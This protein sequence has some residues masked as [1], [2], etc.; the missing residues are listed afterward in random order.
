MTA[1]VWFKNDLR[2][3][4]NAALSQACKTGEPVRAIYLLSPD[5]F[6]QHHMAE[7]KADYIRRALDELAKNLG[8]L[9]IPLDFVNASHFSDAP[10]AISQ[11]CQAHKVTS[12][13]CNAEYLINEEQRDNA[14]ENALE[15]PLKTYHEQL[16]AK[17]GSILNQQDKPYRVFTPFSKTFK[18]RLQLDLPRCHPRPKPVSAEIKPTKCPPLFGNG[19]ASNWPT[20]E[21]ALLENLRTFCRERAPDYKTA[22]DFPAVDGTSRLSAPLS[23]GL[24][25]ARQCLARLLMEQEPKQ[26]EHLWSN[27][28]GVGCWL[29]ELIWREFYHH[30]Y[31]QFS[32][33]VKGKSFKP[34]Y[35]AI[36]WR[37]NQ[38]E[39]DAWCQGKTGYPIVDAAMRQLNQT[40]W[41][42]N[43]LRMITAS[44]LV[45]DL[46][47]D[48]R[49]GEQY[50]MRHLIDGDFASNNGGWQ[51]AASSGCDAAP[52]FRIFNPTTQGQRFDKD[53]GFIKHFLPELSGLQGKALHQPNTSSVNY[54]APIVDHKQARELT[55]DMYKLALA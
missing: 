50:F 28:S 6:Q 31:Q 5:Q 40:G 17:P 2:C 35:D 41:M 45:K 7:I 27:D 36:Q 10:K 25:S 19:D 8:K 30:L 48:W 49:W 52:Y 47:I 55:L 26:M 51:W 33:A 32:H 42:H 23:I 14:V 12:L 15:I 34:E 21:I 1:L 54:P 20:E 18:N 24:L 13:H 46:Q 53:G 3:L 22:R 39:F 4:D 43:R 9:G 29:N 44:F 11:Y 16:L 38:E 37:N